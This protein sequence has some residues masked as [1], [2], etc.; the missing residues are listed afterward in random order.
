MM[1]KELHSQIKSRLISQITL[2]IKDVIYVDFDTTDIK[3]YNNDT[4]L[5]KI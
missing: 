5:L 1:L 2:S 4:G 3:C